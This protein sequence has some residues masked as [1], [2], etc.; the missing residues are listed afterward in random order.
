[1]VVKV[2]CPLNLELSSEYL[3]RIREHLSLVSCKVVKIVERKGKK[4][5]Q[6]QHSARL[7]KLLLRT[8]VISW[9]VRNI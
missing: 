7:A 5:Q 1:M 6:P 8:F 3:R 4:P 2:L 9:N